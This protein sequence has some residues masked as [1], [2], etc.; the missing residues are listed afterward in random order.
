[1]STTVDSYLAHMGLEVGDELKHYGKKGMKWGVRKKERP[2]R[3][4]AADSDTDVTKKVKA[5][6]NG[7][8]DSQ[9]K[10]KYATSKNTYAKRVEKHGDP[11]KAKNSEKNREIYEARERQ[12]AR[13]ADLQRQA[14]KTY[15]AN[16]E[17]AAKAAMNKYEKMELELLSNPDAETAAK[18]TSGEKVATA[19]NGTILVASLVA[20]V[21][22]AARR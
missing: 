11:Y 10:A 14:F 2:T 16:G 13:A 9:F 12:G 21:A 15:S 6:Y 5:D 7:L 4:D 20:T 8:S 19:V 17:K 22:L 18:M 3:L 1:M